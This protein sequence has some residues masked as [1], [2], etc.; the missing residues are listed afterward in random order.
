[1]AK[2]L[3]LQFVT[4]NGKT[5]RIIVENPKEPIDPAIVK[6]SMEAIIASNVFSTANGNLVFFG[7]ARVIDRNITEFEIV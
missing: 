7:G 4:E 6:L 3:E 5:A 2:T 1:M